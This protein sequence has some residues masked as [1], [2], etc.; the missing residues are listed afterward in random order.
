MISNLFWFSEALKHVLQKGKG[1]IC[2]I[3][4][5]ISGALI[6]VLINDFN[7]ALQEPQV[8]QLSVAEFN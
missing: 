3:F 4:P 6:R 7:H 5:N 2:K 8:Q 1:D